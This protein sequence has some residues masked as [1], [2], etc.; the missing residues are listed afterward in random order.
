MLK[1]LGELVWGWPLMGL[2]LFVGGL[3][4]V[5]LRGIQFRKL[6]T[7]FRLIGKSDGSN[8]ITPYGALCTALAAT[9]G[10]GNIV[11]V[12]TALSIGGPGALFWMLLA[13]FLGMATQYAEAFLA[14]KY[15]KIG[16]M[17]R[18][19][20]PYLYMEKG[21][22]CPI[23]AKS[24]A[25][26]GA[27]AGLLGVGTMTQMN[28]ITNGIESL[29]R[30]STTIGGYPSCV[31]ISGI[32]VCLLAAPVLLGGGKRITVV[33][34]TLVPLMS[35]LYLFCAGLI[36]LRH[37][38]Q[39]PSAISLIFRSAFS[40]EAAFGA[41]GGVGISTVLRMGI[42]RGIFTNEAGLGT[43]SIAAASASSENPHHQGLISMT[44]TFID[45]IVICTITGLTLVVTGAW[46]RPLEGGA[47]TV[48]AWKKGLPWSEDLSAYLLTLCLV[49]FAFATIIGWSFYA[50]SC[51]LYLTKGRGLFFYRIAYLG[52][53]ALGPF[54]S[55]S[56]V[57]ELA[58]ILNAMMAVPN[59][60]ALLFL[61]KDIRKEQK[62]YG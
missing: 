59:L 3:Y 15:R 11:G 7:A 40:P 14:H 36:L 55:V 38:N 28:S 51:L 29:S 5:L 9:I 37:G 32:A 43:T 1:A 41:A 2:I 39:I 47:L 60:T 53:L 16:P 12:A 19:G 34:E 42:G 23:L 44:G 56:A 46:D 6:G 61:Q 58:D 27:A 52:A 62:N 13:A 8:G 54:F 20:G 30:S 57:W 24:Y 48:F 50:E 22:K 21:L 4:T 26:I 45:T 35:L 10:T 25:L 31:V 18:Y 49:F 17:G 33:C